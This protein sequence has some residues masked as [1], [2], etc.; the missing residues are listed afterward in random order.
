M[1]RFLDFE[2]REGGGGGGVG[3]GRCCYLRYTE[4]QN[5]RR[6]R[7]KISDV[8]F[9]GRCTFGFSRTIIKLITIDNEFLQVQN[10]VELEL[11]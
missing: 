2:Y 6:V 4:K 7:N 10:F 8:D 11:K 3:G 5:V 9:K 1:S